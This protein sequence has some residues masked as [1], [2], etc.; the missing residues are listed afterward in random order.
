MSEDKPRRRKGRFTKGAL[1][2]LRKHKYWTEGY[3][4]GYPEQTPSYEEYG[5][6]VTTPVATSTYTN[7]FLDVMRR[8]VTPFDSIVSRGF[9][10]SDT[11]QEERITKMALIH[12]TK[13]SVERWHFLEDLEVLSS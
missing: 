4:S 2:R 13:S 3:S 12:W 10:S 9:K 7:D 1:V 11:I 5:V 6:V 8:P